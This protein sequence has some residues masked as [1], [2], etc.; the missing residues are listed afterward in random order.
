M[1]KKYTQ[2]IGL[3]ALTVLST[4]FYTGCNSLPTDDPNSPTG[5]VNK[6][7]V[8]ELVTK[9]AT[10]ELLGGDKDDAQ[11]IVDV[12]DLVLNAIGDEDLVTPKQVDDYIREFILTTDLQPGSKQA[13]LTLTDTLSAQYVARIN[14]GQ[15][16]GDNVAKIAT[17]VR[18]VKVAAEDTLKYGAPVDYGL[19]PE[20]QTRRRQDLVGHIMGWR[21]P[22]PQEQPKLDPKW[23]PGVIH[24]LDNPT[25]MDPELEQHF[26]DE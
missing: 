22:V 2:L 21:E 10:S 20:P 23:I 8:F 14:A 15:L 16:D 5:D 17:V 1:D 11:K 6:D 24:M 13:I 26:Q 3:L 9:T 12:S 25:P 4:V 19:P 7:L 18:W